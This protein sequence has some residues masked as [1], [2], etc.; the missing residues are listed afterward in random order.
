MENYTHQLDLTDWP[1]KNPD[2]ELYTDGSFFTKNSVRH[3]G[4]AVGTEFGI[5]KSG[6]LPPNTSAQLVELV[7]LT[8]ALRLSKQQRV[9]IYTDSKYALLILHAHAA[10]WKE[11]GMLTTTGSPIKHARDILAFHDAVLLPKE[12]SVI[13]CKGHQKGEDKIAKGNKAADESAKQAA[14]QEY[15]ASHLLWERTLLPPE[16]PHCQSRKIRKPQTKCIN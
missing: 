11:R 12:V 13:H 14:M 4:F 16:R 10:V 1:L 3:A 6:P 7:A 9:N 15:I 5:L 2:L 8:E